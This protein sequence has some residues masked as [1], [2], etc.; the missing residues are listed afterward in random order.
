MHVDFELTSGDIVALNLH[1]Y[2]NLPKLRRRRQ[3][4]RFVAPAFW[5]AIMGTF[6]ALRRTPVT[7][8]L[9]NILPLLLFGILW[10]VFYPAFARWNFKKAISRMYPQ[11]APVRKLRMAIVPDGISVT[12][13]GGHRLTPWK[14]IQQV[15]VMEDYVYIL[16]DS[17][18]AHVVP[19]RAFP[20]QPA[21]DSF[22]KNVR[23][24]V[25]RR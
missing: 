23:Q 10:L 11:D 12:S 24:N 25:S 7:E 14:E 5:L 15:E 19:R 18:A 3:L 22:A 17:R 4:L 2:D 8:H 21:F 20:D 16:T 9:W 6:F 1:L 13:P